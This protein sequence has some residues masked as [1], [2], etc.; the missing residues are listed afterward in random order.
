MGSNELVV[1]DLKCYIDIYGYD[2]KSS[3]K[4]IP[5]F[6]ATVACDDLWT[7]DTSVLL[8][9]QAILIPY[10]KIILLCPMRCHLNDMLTM[11]LSF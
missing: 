8:I 10:M 6:D 2:S 5:T 7:E 3:H 4:N 9:N 1:H 11:H